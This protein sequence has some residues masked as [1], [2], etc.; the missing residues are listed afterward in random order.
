M[1]MDDSVQL[2]INASGTATITLNRPEVHNAFHEI[3]VAQLTELLHSMGKNDNIRV[4]VLAASG[5]SFSAGADLNWMRRMADYSR[6]ENYKDAMKLATLMQTL[7]ELPKPTIA[8]IQGPAFGGGVG[9]IACCDIAVAAQGVVF[10]LSEVKLGLIPAVIG[11]YV[12]RA[13]GAREARRYFLSGEQFDAQEAYRI[14]LL[15]EIVKAKALDDAI[16]KLAASLCQGGPKAQV[17]AKRLI[18]A[19]EKT[20][21]NNSLMHDTSQRIADIRASK[22]GKEGLNAFL[23]KRKPDWHN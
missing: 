19:I 9:L 21:I 20:P 16:K 12:I 13:I 1:T 2:D 11:P 4:V 23:E 17:A 8:K 6:Q 3:L 10:S 15:H 22:E 14:G 5:Q 7:D 18:Q